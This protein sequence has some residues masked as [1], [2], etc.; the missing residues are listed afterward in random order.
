[1]V[2]MS[3]FGFVTAYNAAGSADLIYDVAGWFT[4]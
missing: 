1:M 2:G 3:D 4:G